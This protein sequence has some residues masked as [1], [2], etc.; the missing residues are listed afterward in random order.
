M[1]AN[2]LQKKNRGVF[3][4]NVRDNVIHISIKKLCNFNINIKYFASGA[5]TFS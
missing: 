1:H 5:E 4:C 3:Y 2:L